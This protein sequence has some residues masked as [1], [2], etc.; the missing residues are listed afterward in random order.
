MLTLLQVIEK[1]I[2]RA[3]REVQPHRPRAAIFAVLLGMVLTASV[4]GANFTASLDRD[5]ISMGENATL[6]LSFE[7]G[8]PTRM[9]EIPSIPNLQIADNGGES[10]QTTIVNGS[11][12]TSLNR[13]FT[14][15]PTQAGK[16]VIPSLKAE[17]DGRAFSSQPLALT[18]GQA[19]KVS[20]DMAFL[21]LIIPKNQ[22]YLG[23][24]LPVELQVY[25]QGARSLEPPHFKEEGFTL[26][27]LIQ[28]GE[29]QTVRNGH[30]Y[31]ILP[32]KTYVVPVKAGTIDLGPVTMSLQ[33]ARPNSR[34]DFFG[35][36]VDF[37]T[38][39]VESQPETLQVSPLPRE[40]APPTFTGAVGSYSLD[41]NASPTNI[42]VGDPITVKLQISGNGA[43]DS[44]TL[45][46]QENWQQFKLYP[47]TSDFQPADQLGISGVKTFSLTAVPQ[48]TDIKELPPF[49]FSFFDPAQKTYRTLTHAAIPLVVRPSAASLPAPSLAAVPAETPPTNND[50]APIKVRLGAIQRAGPPLALQPWFLS[51]QSIPI[52]AWVG[53]L[54]ERRRK[55]NLAN[56]PRLRR[57]LQVVHI[58]RTGLTQLRDYAQA[59]QPAEFFSTLFRL[60]Q[61]QLGERL[62]VPASSITES[63][64]EE[65]LRPLGVS[66]ETLDLLTRLF[67]ACNQARYARQSTNK[68]LISLI[69]DA[70]AALEQVRKIKA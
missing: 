38:V 23:E 63:I 27:K 29:S 45:P 69:P 68:E 52:I 57:R 54:L 33:V 5:V 13:T 60:L 65:R 39:T 30:R 70:E 7:N 26:G 25:F 35:R 59:N 49:S 46:T 19:G 4:E 51:L 3:R 28:G 21:R 47:P 48:N 44:I 34:V 22:V 9:P 31:E 20:T 24:V 61:E 56:N 15:T 17:I 16:Y 42:A 43:L 55:E 37:Q 66:G 6:T 2:S 12:T 36:P 14:V 58:V 11:V 64:I 18:V 8:R 53:L 41:V 40:N 50:V 67:Q 32:L 1:R 62:D 10:S